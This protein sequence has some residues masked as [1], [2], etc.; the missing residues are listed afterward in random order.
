MERVATYE[1]SAP[2]I[3]PITVTKTAGIIKKLDAFRA[4]GG[5]SFLSATLVNNY[6]DCPLKFYFIAVEELSE[7]S[8]VQ[9]SVESDV[10]GSIFHRLMEAVYNRYRG[11]RLLQMC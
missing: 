8:E 10:F 4:G 7:E 9:E 3:M 1:V 11:V 6:I 2:M 5:E